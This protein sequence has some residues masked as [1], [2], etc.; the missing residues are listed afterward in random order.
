MLLGGDW[1]ADDLQANATLR[2]DD[3]SQYGTRCHGQRQR[4][5]SS[6]AAVAGGAE[7]G[8]SFKGANLQR[9]LLPGYANPTLRPSVV[10]IS[11]R[12]PLVCR[13]INAS[14]TVYQNNVRD[15]IQF[16][17]TPTTTAR[18]RTSPRPTAGRD[19][20]RRY[21]VRGTAW[22]AALILRIRAQHHD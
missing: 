6:G 10:R 9:S 15:L 5:L 8:T 19:A 12:F 20:C 21:A 1:A 7:C 22:T 18:R 3:S 13:G 4:W 14:L 2:L 11:V 17:A 16:G